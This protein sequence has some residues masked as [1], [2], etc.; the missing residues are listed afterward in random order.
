[1]CFIMACN[2]CAKPQQDGDIIITVLQYENLLEHQNINHIMNCLK[3]FHVTA[4]KII[5]S[6]VRYQ[7]FRKTYMS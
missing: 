1:M 2:D 7:C 6:A 3:G 5:C 4:I